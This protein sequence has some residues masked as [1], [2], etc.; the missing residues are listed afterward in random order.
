MVKD[1]KKNKNLKSSVKKR[2]YYFKRENEVIDKA[3]KKKT[4]LEK[5]FENMN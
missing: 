4:T 2:S 3:R 5:N 1:H